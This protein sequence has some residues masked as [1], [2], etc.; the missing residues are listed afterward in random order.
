[1]MCQDVIQPIK[2]QFENYRTNHICYNHNPQLYPVVDPNYSIQKYAYEHHKR[3]KNLSLHNKTE[4]V[5]RDN[6]QIFTTN[7]QLSV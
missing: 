2:K 1:M 6:C 7:E 5:H 3:P 4:H